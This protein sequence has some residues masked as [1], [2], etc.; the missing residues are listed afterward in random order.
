M[1]AIAPREGC[2]C[3]QKISRPHLRQQKLFQSN[4]AFGRTENAAYKIPRHR[5]FSSSS[6]LRAATAAKPV[7]TNKSAQSPF[8]PATTS[9]STAPKPSNSTTHP[10]AAALPS[11]PPPHST[12]STSAS[13]R[14]ATPRANGN[15]YANRGS[16]PITDLTLGLA[17]AP[18]APIPTS[19]SALDAPFLVPSSNG[20]P[21][22]WTRSFHGLSTSPFSEE[23]QRILQER[24][25]EADIEIK[26]DGLAYLPEIKYRRILNRAFGPGGWGLA[27]RGE[28]LVTGK[29]VTREY[30]LVVHGRCVFPLCLALHLPLPNDAHIP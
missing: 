4:T 26:P 23:A 12:S 27:P 13:A 21:V 19:E 11:N 7:T 2:R 5:H 30:G 15:N 22:D 18:P 24:L 8:R 17:D 10:P 3:L 6:G 28:T 16:P 9:S 1:T 29:S 14:T 20:Q 25:N